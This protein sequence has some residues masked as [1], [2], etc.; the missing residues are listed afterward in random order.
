MKI[1]ASTMLAF[2]TALLSAAVSSAR[3]DQQTAFASCLAT[4]STCSLCARISR[5]VAR[6]A[7]RRRGSP[8]SSLRAECEP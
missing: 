5:R 4:P 3:V 2:V 8:A 6:R 1:L 7:A